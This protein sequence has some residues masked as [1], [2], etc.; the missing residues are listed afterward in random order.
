MT[1][2]QKPI[3]TEQDV[4]KIARLARLAINAADIE[5]H[6]QSL[7]HILEMI[8]HINDQDTENVAAMFSPLDAT[9]SLREDAVTAT[10]QR[11]TLQKLAPK[12]ES[13]FYLVPQVIE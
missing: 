2:N 11:E 7:A 13:G 9:L 5:K 1:Q 8:A 3:I 4:Q 12:T 6:T 10:N